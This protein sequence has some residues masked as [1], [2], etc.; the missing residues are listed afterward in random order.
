[1]RRNVAKSLIT[2]NRLDKRGQIVIGVHDSKN[3]IF[4]L[5][6]AQPHET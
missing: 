1:M 4:S 2:S 6:T 5:I 3:Y